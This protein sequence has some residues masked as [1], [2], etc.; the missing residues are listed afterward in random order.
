[1]GSKRAADD[2]AQGRAEMQAEQAAE[3]IDNFASGGVAKLL[4]E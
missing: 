1:M 4:G 2:F 3:E